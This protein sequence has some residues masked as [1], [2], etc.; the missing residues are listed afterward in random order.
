MKMSVECGPGMSEG[1]DS[2]VRSVV[3]PIERSLRPACLSSEM[4][5]AVF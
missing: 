1:L 5:L 3:V 4:W 2:S